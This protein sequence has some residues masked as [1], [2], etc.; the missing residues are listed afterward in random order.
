MSD[1]IVE[2]AWAHLQQAKSALTSYRALID[3]VDDPQEVSALLL[4]VAEIRRHVTG[5]R[6]KTETGA[7]RQTELRLL[8]L[9]DEKV[10]RTP[11]GAFESKWQTRRTGWR[12]DA[13]LPVVVARGLDERKV[14]PETGEYEREGEA[15]A[16]ALKD[17]I[18]FSGGKVT[19]L[20]ARGINPD[21]FCNAEYTGQ[22][23][24]LP[25]A[26]KDG[27]EAA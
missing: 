25:P 6:G 11:L 15:V 12:Y 13:L 10:L 27:E 9:M 26:N 17:C 8:S 23:V 4:E 21:E 24:M 22:T 3:R 18:S 14:D 20:K 1:T 2:E 5:E 16:R 19:G 7:Y